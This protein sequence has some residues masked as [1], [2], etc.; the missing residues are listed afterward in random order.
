MSVTRGSERIDAC[1][2]RSRL[3][4]CQWWATLPVSRLAPTGAGLALILLTP[5][6]VNRDY[7]PCVAARG[8]RE[9]VPHRGTGSLRA[10][11]HIRECRVCL[12]GRR[13][14]LPAR[15]AQA[16]GA[17][18]A[19]RTAA[20]PGRPI[21]HNRSPKPEKAKERTPWPATADRP[22]QFRPHPCR[23]AGTDAML[24]ARTTPPP[25]AE[26][27]HPAAP[28]QSPGRARPRRLPVL[29]TGGRAR[30]R[31]GLGVGAGW[32]AGRVKSDE[33]LRNGRVHGADDDSPI[34]GPLPRRATPN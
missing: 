29:P 17:G 12:L 24:A 25:Q 5:T 10:P 22:R 15:R 20:V 21:E 9:P 27:A 8:H 28:L 11:L 4:E 6:E 34:P 26:K 16:R 14:R 2:R 13:C 31:R 32:Q 33:Q 1:M 3:R 23:M 7:R 30:V 19:R 18:L